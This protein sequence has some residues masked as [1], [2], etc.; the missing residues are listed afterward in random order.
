MW[1]VVELG[2]NSMKQFWA[3]ESILSLNLRREV[4]KDDNSRL[5]RSDQDRSNQ[6]LEVVQPRRVAVDQLSSTRLVLRG[7]Y[8]GSE[9]SNSKITRSVSSGR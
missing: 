8:L 9:A 4:P 1:D 7:T 3:G 5:I 6:E 2:N